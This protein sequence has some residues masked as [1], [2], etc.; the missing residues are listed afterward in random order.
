ML[1]LEVR[2]VLREVFWQQSTGHECEHKAE[3]E[4]KNYRLSCSCQRRGQCLCGGESHLVQAESG[5][6]KESAA[7]TLI[8]VVL[9][10]THV[11]PLSLIY[12][13]QRWRLL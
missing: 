6:G 10:P 8:L 11:A 9:V 2:P 7:D 5:G 3:T 13:P 1:L 12:K 4:L